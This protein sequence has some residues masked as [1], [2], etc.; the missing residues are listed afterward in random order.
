MIESCRQFLRDRL[1]ELLLAD[2]TRAYATDAMFF[3]DMPRD[4]LKVNRFGVNCLPLTD[5]KTRDGQLI[6]RQKDA[7]GTHYEMIRRTYRRKVLFRCF[8][9]AADF[10]DLWGNTS[11]T[12]LVDQF[13][14]AVAGHRCMAD[15][16]NNSIFINLHDAARP[17]DADVQK[18]RVK[19]MP[20]KAIVRVEFTG[21]V[22]VVTRVPII[23]G[24]DLA[25]GVSVTVTA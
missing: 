14:Q 10:A 21:G 22:H 13:G 23:P 6:G 17:W 8:L 2:G 7:A 25:N 1:M 5:R 20:H 19:L 4:W 15:G 16:T 12:G 18:E 9:Y 3:G 11:F 24:I